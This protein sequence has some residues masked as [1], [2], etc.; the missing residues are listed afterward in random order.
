MPMIM[1]HDDLDDLFGDS[2]P[3]SLPSASPIRGLPQ[4]V[5]ELRLSGCTQYVVFFY[6]LVCKVLRRNI[7]RLHG[8]ES[9]ALRI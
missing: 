3:L 6:E 2:A 9:G 8:P 4:R 5:D 1:D 7:G